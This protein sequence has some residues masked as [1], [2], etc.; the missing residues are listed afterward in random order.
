MKLTQVRVRD[1]LP[2]AR[3]E[4]LTAEFDRILHHRE[5]IVRFFRKL[6]FKYVSLDLLGYK[7]G[8]MNL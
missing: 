4:V 6:G 8:S 1:H 5:R 2:I 7:T 3:I